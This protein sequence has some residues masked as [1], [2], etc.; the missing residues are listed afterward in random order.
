MPDEAV[1]HD[2]D[3]TAQPA[4]V[5]RRGRPL[6]ADRTDA[7]LTAANELFDEVGYD[8]LTVQ[9]IAAR[10]GV[11]LA[12]LYRRWPSKNALVI[13]ALRHRQARETVLLEGPPLEQLRALFHAIAAST[14]GDQSEFLPGLLAA[15]RSEESVGDDLREGILDPLAAVI[16]SLLGEILG[17]DHPQ[18][19]LLVDAMPAVCVWKAL[20]PTGPVDVDAMVGAY[21]GLVEQLARDAGR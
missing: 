18:I 17:A 2:L 5:A 19:D 21:L 10:A 6:A 13:D 11:G 1:T 16:R 3:G 8:Q 9:D 20:T 7:I 15:I 4:P 12:T 14:V